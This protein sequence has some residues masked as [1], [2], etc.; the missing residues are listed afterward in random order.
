MFSYL[1]Y[2]L[3]HWSS[4]R[5]RPFDP[6]GGGVLANLLGTDNLFSS[7]G[8]PENLFPGKPRTEYLF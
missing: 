8:R 3:R 6:E 1:L 7:R 2:Y 5:G 4:I